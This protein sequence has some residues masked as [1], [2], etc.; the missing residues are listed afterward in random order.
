MNGSNK[1]GQTFILDFDDLSFT[2]PGIEYLHK[3]KEHYPDFRCTAFTPAFDIG[4]FM[5]K[6][7][8][9]KFKQW[10]ELLQETKD[11]IEIAPHGFAHLRGECLTDDRQKWETLLNAIEHTF[12]QIGVDFVKVFKAPYWEISKVGEE[13]LKERG[14]VLAIDRNNPK[15]LTDIPTYVWNWSIDEMPIPKYHTIKGHG[16]VYLTNNGLDSC[17]PNLL[18]IPKGTKFITVSEYLKEQNNN[19]G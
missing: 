6:V 18:K 12:E 8:I 19:K 9:E 10:G 4:V 11:W 3:M 14:Y 2:K 13:I 15:T 1:D 5:K 7:S 16:H 17:L